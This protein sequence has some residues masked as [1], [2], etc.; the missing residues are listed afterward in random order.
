MIARN[1]KE[2]EERMKLDAGRGTRRYAS[3]AKRPPREGCE[4]F[5]VMGPSGHV[6]TV[7]QARR[8]KDGS[9]EA[10]TVRRGLFAKRLD[11]VPMDD[12]AEIDPRARVVVVRRAAPDGRLHRSR[13]GGGFRAL[14]SH[15]RVRDVMS[16]PVV[17]ALPTATLEELARLMLDERVGSVVIVD[18]DDPGRPVGIV[19]E[20]DF[21]VVD[22]P[23]PF[24]FFKWPSVFGRAV[25]SEESLEE[26]YAV[27]RSRSAESVMSKPVATVADEAE[28]WDAV[29]VMVA[30]DV[31][32]VPVLGDGSLVGIVT[33]H[34]LLKC[35]AGGTLEPS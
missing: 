11:V 13:S 27:A 8:R 18:P 20:T 14:T 7:V 30:D 21:E 2:G 6:G 35:L 29:K 19:T 24:T 28:L 25:W 4:G 22:R 31:K 33:R 12:V 10:L 23:V 32:R 3:R 1:S 26:V 34:D 5:R 15:L 17:T 16:S 9:T